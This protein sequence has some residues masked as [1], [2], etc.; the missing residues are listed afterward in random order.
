MIDTKV[1]IKLRISRLYRPLSRD[2]A[3][4]FDKTPDSH[5]RSSF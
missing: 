5:E 2:I 1:G 4:K 3:Q